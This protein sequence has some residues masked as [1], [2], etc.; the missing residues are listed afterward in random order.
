MHTAIPA[1]LLPIGSAIHIRT[2]GSRKR[3]APFTI[4][5]YFIGADGTWQ[6]KAVDLAGWVHMD[7]I[8]TLSP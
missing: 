6:F 5:S 8:D 3:S 4:E 2:M 1:H 7:S